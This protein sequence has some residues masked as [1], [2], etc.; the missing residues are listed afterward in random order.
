VRAVGQ[1][2][3]DRQRRVEVG[4]HLAHHRDAGVAV[5]GKASKLLEP[6]VGAAALC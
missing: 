6:L 1:L 2:Q 4:Q 5:G 3:V